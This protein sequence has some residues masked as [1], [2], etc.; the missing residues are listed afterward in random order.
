MRA[1]AARVCV[2]GSIARTW[3]AGVL[4]PYADLRRRD[5][6]FGS[7]GAPTLPERSDLPLHPTRDSIDFP[8][9]CDA[10]LLVFMEYQGAPD[11]VN[12]DSCGRNIM[13]HGAGSLP[14]SPRL[15]A[16]WW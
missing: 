7:A 11:S 16:R 2:N 12:Q 15:G 3:G 4:R 5:I 1:A 14:F 13:G 8:A 10:I 9:Q 6:Q